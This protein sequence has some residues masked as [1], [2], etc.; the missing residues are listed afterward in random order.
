MKMKVNVLKRI[1]TVAANLGSVYEHA[2]NLY[3]IINSEFEKSTDK[4]AKGSKFEKIDH[5]TFNNDG[6]LAA[7][8]FHFN[9]KDG[10]AIR[11]E[12]GK[13]NEIQ[14]GLF[15]IPLS[16]YLEDLK[17]DVEIFEAYTSIIETDGKDFKKVLDDT[18]KKCVKFIKDLEG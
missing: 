8:F 6:T 14:I 3:K 5:C 17:K 18:N 7:C 13:N 9:Y 10:K 1:S 2:E 15:G 11:F 12:I 4:I 16:G